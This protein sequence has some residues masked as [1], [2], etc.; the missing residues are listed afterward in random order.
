MQLII[1]SN[2]VS[3]N[4]FSIII[5]AHNEEGVI[6]DTIR[7]A[8]ALEYPRDRCEVIVIENGSSDATLEEAR[9]AADS[10][11]TVMSV[12]TRG[13]SSARN[14]GINSMNPK[15]DWVIFLDADTHV[16][17]QFLH[18][19]NAYITRVGADRYAVGTT[20]LQPIQS[21]FVARF[22]FGVDNLGHFLSKTSM[23]IFIVRA[24]AMEGVHFDETMTNAEDLKFINQVR[25]HGKFF[26]F[27]TKTVSTS[28]R[29]F[30]KEGWLKV[31]IRWVVIALLP[32]SM[33]RRMV[34][35]VT[36]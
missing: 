5:P 24:R 21:S 23:S 20:A 14:A 9:R 1:M 33:Q 11:V 30:L 36:R 28:T 31:H 8:Q 6:G 18:G 27:N 7:H 17:P 34:Y 10:S 12:P 15:T 19:L 35:K 32:E 25:K 16:A 4:F 13:V 3:N 22:W 26:F 29:R 2:T